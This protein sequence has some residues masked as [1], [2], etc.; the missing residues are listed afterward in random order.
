MRNTWIILKREYLERV[1]TRTFLVLTLLAPAIMTALMILPVKLATLGQNPEH[2]VIVAS[3]QQFGDTVRQQLLA[4]P[5]VGE[6]KRRRRRHGKTK[7]R[8]PLHHRC[9]HN[10]DRGGACQATRQDFRA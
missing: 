5:L 3:T 4:E 7:A 10:C 1:R 9:G 2:I 6:E 8:R